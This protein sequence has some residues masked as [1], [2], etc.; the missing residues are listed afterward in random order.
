MD[1]SLIHIS[2]QE[3]RSI[4][5]QLFYT[6][7]FGVICYAAINNQKKAYHSGMELDNS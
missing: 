5:K 2:D 1:L 6:I 4:I 7:K 3:S